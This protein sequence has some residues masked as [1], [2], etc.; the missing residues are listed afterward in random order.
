MAEQ[1]V[2][3]LLPAE[4]DTEGGDVVQDGAFDDRGWVDE[5]GGEGVFDGALKVLHAGFV[6]DLGGSQPEILRDR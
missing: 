3:R 4:E 2:I 5:E 1:H 6:R